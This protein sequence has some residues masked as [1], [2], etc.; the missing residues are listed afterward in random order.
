LPQAPIDLRRLGAWMDAQGLEQGA[1]TAGAVLAGGT[2]NILYRFTRGGR[3]Y[4]L[5]HPPAKPRPNSNRIM[6][7]EARLL[8]ALG[9][10]RVPHPQLIASCNDETVLGAVFYLME[11]VDGFNPT[12]AMPAQAD[13]AARRKMGLDLTDALAALSNLPVAPLGLTDFG[14]PEGYLERQV[15]RWR[16]EL[17]GYA[18]FEAWNGRTDLGDVD[19]IGDWLERNRPVRRWDGIVHGDYHIGNAIFSAQGELRAIVDWEMATL[20]DPLLDF[21]RLLLSWPVKGEA[22]AFTMRVKPLDGFPSR[23]E[24][25]ARYGERTGCDLSALPWF[26]ALACYKLGI[27]LEGTYARA[28][29]G[30]ADKT[31]GDRFH[32]AVI[33][34]LDHTRR[35]IAGT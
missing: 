11:P 19:S 29:A 18:R 16:G 34:L 2:Q 12:V 32:A 22:S 14:N 7:R 28:Q 24:M 30:L 31:T 25:A 9:K 23:E 3:E 4:V 5:R 13:A 26:E 10:T 27:I 15:R 20:G 35:L 17:E 6:Q 8:K 33:A 21:C 1:I